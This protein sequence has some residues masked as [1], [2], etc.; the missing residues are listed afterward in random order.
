MERN[1]L[2]KAIYEEAHLTGEFTLR[3]GQVAKEYFDKF[4]FEANPKLLESIAKKM[5]ELIPAECEVL[6]GL[7]M[8][9]I[10]ITAALS[11]QSGIPASYVRKKAK[12]YGTC[13]LAEGTNVAGRKVCIVED[14]VTTGGQILLSA[15]DLRNLGAK[16]D[17]VL[18]V[19]QRGEDAARILAEAGLQLIPLFS[20]DEL[21]AAAL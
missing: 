2:A 11:L 1:A 6:A 21:K 3:S 5:A 17:T 14:V 20:M 16:V 10:P 8:G 9:A 12:E 7:E 15:A 18:C 4:L 19:I 13:K